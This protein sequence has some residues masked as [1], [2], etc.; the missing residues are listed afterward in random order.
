MQYPASGAGHL[1]A[2]G[3][4][5]AFYSTS[6]AG[7]CKGLWKLVRHGMAKPPPPAAADKKKAA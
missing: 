6:W 3:L 4:V 7:A 5:E 1:F 2:Q